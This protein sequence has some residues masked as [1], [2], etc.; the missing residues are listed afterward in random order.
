MWLWDR[1]EFL[2]N[3]KHNAYKK[4]WFIEFDQNLNFYYSKDAILKNGES[5]TEQ[6]FTART[7]II[8]DKILVSKTC[9]EIIHLYKKINNI[10]KNTKIFQ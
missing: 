7:C 4:K 1:Q 9:K 2:R 10:F 5:E 6:V 8:S 3:K